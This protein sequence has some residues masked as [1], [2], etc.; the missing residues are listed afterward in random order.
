MELL[1]Q[2]IHICKSLNRWCQ[3]DLM[4]YMNISSVPCV[5]RKLWVFSENRNVSKMPWNQGYI[6]VIEKRENVTVCLVISNRAI[7]VPVI[8]NN[9]LMSLHTNWAYSTYHSPIEWGWWKT[10]SEELINLWHSQWRTNK[11]IH[12]Q[13]FWLRIY[14]GINSA[15]ISWGTVR[16][17]ILC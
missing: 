6:P 3:I 9:C 4:F 2:I 1:N 14:S 16:C 11:T 13:A 15:H 7:G 17:Q 5:P 10:P 12:N 8:I